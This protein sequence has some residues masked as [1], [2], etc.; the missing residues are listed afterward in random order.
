MPEH[1]PPPP[2][3]GGGKAAETTTLIQW[4]KDV[5]TGPYTDEV[6]E[7]AIVNAFK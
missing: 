4:I 5:V 7:Q 2:T 6:K 1:P 3:G